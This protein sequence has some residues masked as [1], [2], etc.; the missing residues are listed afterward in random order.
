MVV[1]GKKEM[2]N[3]DKRTRTNT[4]I[5][6][7]SLTPQLGLSQSQLTT[8]TLYEARKDNSNVNYSCSAR[9]MYT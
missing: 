4:Q 3:P 8:L 5:N 7:Y 2:R 9:C 1:Y 6:T